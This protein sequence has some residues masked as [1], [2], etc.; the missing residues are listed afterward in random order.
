MLT[1]GG[2][3]I[4][5]STVMEL[6]DELLHPLPGVAVHRDTA[7]AAIDTVRKTVTS[8]DGRVHLAYTGSAVS[9]LHPAS[10]T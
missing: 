9:L 7:V 10:H 3:L 6:L 5:A 2:A 4:Y 8:E 1:D